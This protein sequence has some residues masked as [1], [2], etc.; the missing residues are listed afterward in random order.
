MDKCKTCGAIGPETPC[1]YP[2]E[3]VQQLQAENA[4]L[5]TALLRQR[6]QLED[7]ALANIQDRQDLA[8]AQ[9]TIAEMREAL[10]RIGLTGLDA[11]QI[12]DDT[13]A[14]PANLDA[15][16]EALARELEEQADWF[17]NRI[18][19]GSGGPYDAEWVILRKEA[20]AHRARKQATK[21]EGK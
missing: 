16:H 1:A 7:Y 14:I 8:A 20:A 6:Q 2:T 17:E 11:R 4:R 9:A 21:E 15:L 10:D 12:A 3:M 5:N 13:L 19:N 18:K